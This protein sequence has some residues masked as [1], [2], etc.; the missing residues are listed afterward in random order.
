MIAPAEASANLA[1][2]DGV[3]Y[4]LRAGERADAARHVRDARAPRASAPRSSAGSCSARSRCRPATTT[5]TT[6]ARSG[7][8]R[9][10]AEDFRDRLR[11]VATSSSRRRRRRVA[12]KLGERT[13]DPLAMYLSDYCTVPMPLAGIPRDLDSGRARAAGRRQ[14][15]DGGLPVGLQ[16]AG[17]AFSE[18]A[19]LDAAYALEQAIGF[20]PT[21]A[22]V[23]LSADWEPVIGLEIHVQL[24]DADEDVLRL[25]AVVRRGAQHRAPCPVC[26]GHPGTLP[27]LNEQAVQLAA[28]DRRSRSGA[29][30]RRDRSSTARTTSIPT[31]PRA[32]RSASTTFRSAPA[33]SSPCPAA[34]V[35][36][37]RVHLEEDAGEADPRRRVGPHPRRRRV[38]WSTSTAAARRWSRSSPSPT[39]ASAADAREFLQ[40]LRTTLK[41]IG[42]S[43]VNMEEGSLRCDANVSVREVGEQR[44]RARRPS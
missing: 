41:Q 32:T 30:S 14:R 36:I 37:H 15:P 18:N 13:D 35:R 1:R 17:P 27:V 9:K 21:G 10:I 44:A 22:I 33:A 2:Y 39:C 16:I 26:L 6:G 5:P 40:L 43:D 20:D 25:R 42:V 12:F 38:A 23:D 31:C 8:A 4:G 19:M 11:R 29:R 7:C 28:D 24:A 34:D 3:R